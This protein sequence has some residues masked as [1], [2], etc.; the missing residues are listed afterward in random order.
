MGTTAGARV[1]ASRLW[2]RPADLAAAFRAAEANGVAVSFDMYPYRMASTILADLLLPAGLQSGGPEVT[3][4]ALRDPARRAD[5]LAGPGFSAASLSAV[6]L[7]CLP[8][9][10]AGSAGQSVT[11]AAAAAGRSPGEWVLDLLVSAD[12][13]VGGHLDRPELDERELAVI[14]D[15]DRF[16]AGSDGIYQG[17]H[18][19][20]RG[21]GAFAELAGHY[22]NGDPEAGY[23]R[24]ARHLAAAPAAA[25]GLRDRG[26]LAPGLAADI[27]VIGPGGLV[28]RASYERPAELAVGVDLVIVNGGI[29]WRGGRPTGA[30]PGL[31][32]S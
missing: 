10:F 20:P 28:A 21:Y 6:F 4:A 25:Y 12:L 27:C 29:V 9:R 13:N 11:A 5:L 14:T 15:D 26:R 24:I 7:G 8:E 18:P 16:C 30:R 17:Q 1:H 19:H 2:G 22:L 23:Q 32:V 31:L 3:L